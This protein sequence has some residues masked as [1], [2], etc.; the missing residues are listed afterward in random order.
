M[1]KYKLSFWNILHLNFNSIIPKLEQLLNNI[2]TFKPE[3]IS[4]Q[5]TKL[6]NNT[7]LDIPGYNIFR[8][9]ISNNQGG[10]HIAVKNNI[11]A[12]NITDPKF[13]SIQFLE[14]HIFSIK[15]NIIYYHILQPT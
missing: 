11:P 3:I 12:V 15:V 10:I 4:I 1:A 2:D 7:H 8:K 6:S 5:E 13:N 14:I 9:D